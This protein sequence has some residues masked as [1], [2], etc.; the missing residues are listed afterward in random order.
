MNKIAQLLKKHCPDGVGFTTFQALLDEKKLS[1]VVPPKKL[2]KKYYNE[3]GAFPIVDQGQNF[4]VGYTN[5]KN[6][7]LDEGEYVIFGDHTEA[8][9]YV[10]FAFAQGAD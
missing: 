2:T 5:D 3:S 1:T 10:D 8:I 6:S 9:K 4:I 7:V